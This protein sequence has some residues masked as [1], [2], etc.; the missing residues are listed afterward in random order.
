DR[1]RVDQ[2]HFDVEHEVEQ[3]DDVEAEVE[4]HPAAADGRLAAFVD[5][6]LLGVGELRA[7]DRADEQVDQHEAQAEAQ[8][9]SDA[10]QLFH[11]ADSAVC[12]GRMI[13]PRMGAL[14]SPISPKQGSLGA[15]ASRELVIGSSKS[16]RLKSDE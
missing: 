9:D 11:E 6:V 10:E 4:L 14:K 1:P 15:P 3:R 7:D 12:E 2:R 13:P 16:D 8:E 5:C